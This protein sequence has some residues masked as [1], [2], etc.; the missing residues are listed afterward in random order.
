MHD[1]LLAAYP[2]IKALHLSAVIAFMA[3]MMYLPRLFIYHHQ[4]EQGGEAERHFIA[5]ERRLLKGIIN[6]TLIALWL[7]AGLMLYANPVLLK[8]PWFLTK[9]PLVIG[10]SAAQ[11]FYARA[12][13]KFEAGERPYTQRFWRI[14]NEVPFVLMLGAVFLAVVKPW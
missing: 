12:Q 1:A 8:T 7:F 10:V 2:Y 6:P 3:G 9:L 11:H 4:A 14:M 5:M 13:K